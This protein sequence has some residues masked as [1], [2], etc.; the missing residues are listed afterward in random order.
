MED[1]SCFALDED[2]N[3]LILTLNLDLPEI[4][5]RAKNILYECNNFK[6][7]L[8]STES[9]RVFAYGGDVKSN[10][11]MG[12]PFEYAST[13]LIDYLRGWANSNVLAYF[14][15]NRNPDG[16]RGQSEVSPELFHF[17]IGQLIRYI[18]RYT[19]VYINLGFLNDGPY[20]DYH[21]YRD[22][23]SLVVLFRKLLNLLP[24]DETVY[25]IID[26][27]TF[28]TKLDLP[29]SSK[30]ALLDILKLPEG[31]TSQ[32]TV[33][34]FAAVSLFVEMVELHGVEYVE[35]P[36]G[37]TPGL[38]ECN[39]LYLRGMRTQSAL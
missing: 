19:R 33:T 13:V 2:V 18:K 8:Q 6:E 39:Y 28:C 31:L 14:S 10:D 15:V 30:E 36:P 20:T 16:N 5:A 11:A 27:H 9:K 3:Q 32:V 12:S 26:T 35:L 38:I 25:I 1:D 37:Q 29:Q 24:D 34:I 7:F 4:I 23:N 22:L 21:T 17:L